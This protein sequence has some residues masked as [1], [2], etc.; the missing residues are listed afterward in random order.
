MD[1]DLEDDTENRSDHLGCRNELE[2]ECTAKECNVLPCISGAC[3]EWSNYVT[4][5]QVTGGTNV[6]RILPFCGYP[7]VRFLRL[8]GEIT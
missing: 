7:G 1:T 8:F 4:A 3:C 5:H 6:D 2:D